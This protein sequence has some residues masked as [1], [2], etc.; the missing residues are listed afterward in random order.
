MGGG[1]IMAPLLFMSMHM[2]DSPWVGAAPGFFAVSLFGVSFL[3]YACLSALM[4][5]CRLKH[6]FWFALAIT[7]LTL[8][9]SY[10]FYLNTGVTVY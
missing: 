10:L 4:S 9:A 7:M 1:V 2:S 8:V 3:T 5:A 6:A